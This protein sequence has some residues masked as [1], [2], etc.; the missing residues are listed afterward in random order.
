LADLSVAVQRGT[1]VLPEHLPL[2]SLATLQQLAGAAGLSPAF[3]ALV[4][5]AVKTKGG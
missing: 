5:A 1:S 3:A 4:A 2:L